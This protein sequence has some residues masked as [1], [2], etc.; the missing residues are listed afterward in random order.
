MGGS[1]GGRRRRAKRLIAAFPF[2]CDSG[3]ETSARH[4]QRD[5]QLSCPCH[6][7]LNCHSKLLSYAHQLSSPNTEGFF[8]L[9]NHDNLILLIVAI[10]QSICDHFQ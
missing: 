1:A 8:T 7:C 9:L 6:G 3:T 10:V 2:K 4:L 5:M